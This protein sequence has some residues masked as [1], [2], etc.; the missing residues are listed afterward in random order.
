MALIDDIKLSL[1]VSSPAADVEVAALI[2][3]AISDMRRV[4]VDEQLLNKK[5][6][7][8]L[9]KMAV[10]CYCKANFGYDN[11]EAERFYTIYRQTVCDLMN[12]TI[13]D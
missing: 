7:H 10:I 2:E 6:M 5:K 9:T 11:A 12:S 4:G 1:R 8:P 3:A 13:E